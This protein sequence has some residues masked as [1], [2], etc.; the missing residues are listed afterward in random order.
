MTAIAEIG[1]M[2]PQA[3]EHLEPPE[4][5][6]DKEWITPRASRGSTAL[7]TLW[8][9]TYGFQKSVVKALQLVVIC[10]AAQDN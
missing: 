8:F 7:L 6:R 5:K 4:A 2:W 10:T 9:R 1:V 3:K